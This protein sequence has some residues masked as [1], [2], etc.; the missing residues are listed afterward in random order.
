MESGH[1]WKKG[2][3][4][5]RT[6]IVCL[7]LGLSFLAAV[8]DAQV[9][10]TVKSFGI[11]GNVSGFDPA[12][13]PVQGADGTL[14]GTT[15]DGEG[16]I[17]GVVYKVQPDGS[18]F[19]ALKLFTNSVE[20][21]SPYAGLVLY[22]NVLF[23]T[24]TA[25]GASNQGTVFRL[26]IDGSGFTVL[27]SFT[28]NDGTAPYAELTLSGTILYG[29]TE[30]GGSSSNGTIFSINTDGTGYTVLKEFAGS[31]GSRPNRLI[32][33]NGLLYGTTYQGGSS[34][35]G[36]VFRIGADGSGYTVLKEFAFS[37]S[38]GALPQ[39]G[40]TGSGG[41]LY[42]VTSYGGPGNYGTI[43]KISTNG[44]SFVAL[45]NFIPQAFEPETGLTFAAN[46]LYGTTYSG[47]KGTVFKVGIDGTGFT[48]LT[49]FRDTNGAFPTA[50]VLVSG[51]VLYS[52]TSSGPVTYPTVGL[53]YGTLFRL[54]ADGSGH[55]ILK[56]FAYSDGVS[57]YGDLTISNGVIY[58]TT[59]D[60]GTSENGT[61]F[62]MNTNGTGYTTL[63]NFDGLPNDGTRPESDV[64]LSD[65]VLFGTTVEGG[66]PSNG[67]TV[68]RVNADGTGYAVL[69]ALPDNGPGGSYGG[70]VLSGGVLYGTTHG[71][72]GN[73]GDEGTVF[74]INSDG[75]GYTVLKSFSISD[76]AVPYA[77]LTPSN[78]VLYGTTVAGGANT[79][80]G[81]VF[82]LNTDG[83][84]FTILKSFAGADGRWP[85]GR[86]TLADNVLYGTTAL[87]GDWDN[88]T[89]F[90]VNTDGTGFQVLKSFTGGED[91]SEP[92]SRVI[93]VGGVL[94]GTTTYGGSSGKGTV[95]QMNSD[96]SGFMVLK[97]FSGGIDGG[98]PYYSG[99]TLSGNMLYGTTSTGGLMGEGTVFSID[100]SS[101]L[102]FA[103]A[104][105]NAVV[106]SW[107]NPALTLQAAPTA[108]GVYTNVSGAMSPYTNAFSGG[109][110]F[111][112]LIGN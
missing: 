111:F 46:A 49:T 81:T 105:Q 26:N 73:T 67:G 74:S 9:F 94:Y 35:A 82:K 95:F 56:K 41:D 10:T 53:S 76:G 84:G 70:L 93:L 97:S 20:G 79:Y 99:A 34:N 110:A 52:T 39:G 86:L 58:G 90:R 33:L 2:S 48:V 45:T 59:E 63:K 11:P 98:N 28:G 32:F 101:N 88:G 51:G 13:A 43:F 12:S 112:R 104:S 40:L 4:K 14:Y 44:T 18:G 54:N 100:L 62:R 69:K 85:Y 6:V 65:G 24:T 21:S 25:G 42:G 72:G 77:G 96:G 50:G 61:V 31:D 57:P 80:H 109:Q 78:G 38:D 5:R 1:C 55:T 66:S 68:F 30:N 37:G 7:V 16:S 3:R 17:A 103:Q 106:L 91:G 36:I 75:T 89:V 108:S 22:S 87:G 83:S 19:T 23:G 29:V 92:Q 47:G 8:V 60:G 15:P 27:K 71:S 102:L 64:V 107:A